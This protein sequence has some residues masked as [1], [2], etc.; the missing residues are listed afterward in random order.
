MDL[1]K[2]LNLPLVRPAFSP[3]TVEGRPQREKSC[4]IPTACGMVPE[5]TVK[6]AAK[7]FGAIG[8]SSGTGAAKRRSKAHY[9]RI[10]ELGVKARRKKLKLN[11]I[12]G[13]RLNA[14]SANNR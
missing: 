6:E 14:G 7:A 13:Q 2:R 9:K 12:D 3:S 5:M 4:N 10:S 1:W 8:G 11:S